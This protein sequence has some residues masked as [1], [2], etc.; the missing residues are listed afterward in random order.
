MTNSDK[1]YRRENAIQLAS[2]PGMVFQESCLICDGKIEQGTESITSG[3]R[4]FEVVPGVLIPQYIMLAFGT[5]EVCGVRVQSPR[6]P[7][8]ALETYY[9]GS[10]YRDLIPQPRTAADR[11]VVEVWRPN[12]VYDLVEDNPP[13]VK[14]HLDFGGDTG[15]MGSIMIEKQNYASFLV[16]LSEESRNYAETVHEIPAT[17][18]LPPIAH[19][20][21]LITALEVVE[22]V[23]NPVEVVQSLYN[24][25]EDGG[26]LIISVPEVKKGSPQ[27]FSLHHIHVFTEISLRKL[28][29]RAGVVEPLR[30]VQKTD[31]L[32]LSVTR[33]KL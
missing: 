33:R 30:I 21:G 5:C 26:L 3:I 28:M 17:A 18:K 27:Y 10:A 2:G 4:H 7:D 14:T 29:S 32:F 1:A 19:K 6:M 24:R 15:L 9:T 20:F 31:S 25:L 12:F 8:K 23:P 16:E 11:E 13:S 22:H